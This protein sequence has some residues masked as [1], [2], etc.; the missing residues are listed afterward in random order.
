MKR[1]FV[2]VALLSSVAFAKGPPTGQGRACDQRN[3]CDQGMQCVPRAGGTA[4][5]EIV[6]DKDR[7]CPEDQRCVKD[8][9]QMLCKVISDL[10][11]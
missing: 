9:P 2:A 3:K 10:T 5:C 4:R 6:C 7:E 11:L 8:G 1:I